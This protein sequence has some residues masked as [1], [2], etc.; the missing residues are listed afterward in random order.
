M[1]P[2]HT[3]TAK[4]SLLSIAPLLVAF[5]VAP[6]HGQDL[7]S[8]ARQRLDSGDF[9]AA[10]IE[11]QNAL[12][13]DPTDVA[14]RLMLAEA[15]LLG[16]DGASAEKELLR[17]ADLGAPPSSW[18]LNLID[19]LLL[20]KKFSDALDRLDGGA[21]QMSA[22]EQSRAAALRGRAQLGMMQ[23]EEAAQAFDKA[24]ALDA[25]N[26][27]AALGNVL[28]AVAQGKPEEAA[29]IADGLLQRFPENL[30]AILIR[31]ELHAG[32]NETAEAAERFSQAM[33]LDP[34]NLRA[35]LGHAGAMIALGETDQ[36]EKDLDRADKIQKN[37]VTTHYLRGIL[38]FEAKDWERAGAHLGVVVS[39]DPGD[40]QSQLLMGI[41][42]FKRDELQIAEEYLER[43][44]SA[45]PG[46]PH[47]RKFLGAARIKLA[48]PRQAIAVLEPLARQAPD[49]E[50]MSLLGS[51]YILGGDQEQGQKWL[52]KAVAAAPDA[53][54]LRTQLA[55]TLLARGATG[56]AVYELETA[57]GLGQGVVQ[58]DVMLVLTHIQS[59][60]LDRALQA[61]QALEE[62]MPESAIAK[63][64][65][66][67][68]LLAQGKTDMARARFREAL[69][70]DPNFH[71]AALNIARIEG[72]QGNLDAAR[73]VYEAVLAI[74]PRH[75]DA[76]LGLAALAEQRGD[77]AAVVSWLGKAQDAHPDDVQPGLLLANHYLAS[78]DAL[79][80]MSVMSN[81]ATR[82]PEDP[83][84]LETLGRAY[85]LA[86]ETANAVRTFERLVQLRPESAKA[87]FLLGGARWG[88]EDLAGAAEAFTQALALQPD[89]TPAKIALAKVTLQNGRADDALAL[90]RRLPEDAPDAADGY[91]IE[92]DIHLSE[93]RP[94]EAAKAFD[95]A[96]AIQQNGN[97][98]RQLAKA[99]TAA[100]RRDDALAVL[101]ARTREQPEDHAT[102]LMLGMYYEAGARYKDAAGAYASFVL[103]N[104]DN[105]PVLNN[106]ASLY[107]RLGDPRAEETAKR[108]YELDGDRPEV[109]DTY[110]WILLHNGKVQEGL[111]LLQQAYVAYPTQAEIGYHVAVGL[112]KA[113]RNEESIKL[114]QRLLR[115][116]P[117][118]PRAQE[119]QALLTE[120][121]R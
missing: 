30:E 27:R 120:L 70:L 53:A 13:A 10:V 101:E 15:Y 41:V 93:G 21:E 26:E 80:A 71:T 92:G 6:A 39:K 63:N 116:N 106:L 108:A 78:G 67:L 18:R 9:K 103:A 68:A 44:V 66:G 118:F 31:A 22:A 3:S 52:E 12:Q 84:V 4:A 37:L 32:F 42:S 50:S 115:E 79:K 113:N 61:S 54:A 43:V 47:A 65:T 99:L 81:L 48:K 60:E 102:L 72:A 117:T 56:E 58:T 85:V 104:P 36:A 29:R 100:G 97:T 51:A 23:L 2:N 17:A 19:A 91:A 88:V 62:R 82:F 5:A 45:V 90:A 112:H 69:D 55:M 7:H 110:G 89:F 49:V 64:L 1:S 57:V 96:Y 86:D 14:A 74:Q 33:K 25:E 73:Q 11:L 111:T 34:E 121:E 109:A 8:S 114:L 38:A 46:N 76:M 24:L 28:V 20:Q 40:L 59:G 16:K 83:V 77:P 119:A 98:A 87:H 105:A 35:V 94:A 95:T 75:L 107:Q